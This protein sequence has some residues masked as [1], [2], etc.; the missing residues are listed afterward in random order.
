MKC[1]IY[2][3]KQ[4]LKTCHGDILVTNDDNTVT[5]YVQNRIIDMKEKEKGKEKKK[6]RRS[7]II[8]RVG[9]S[10]VIRS[11]KEVCTKVN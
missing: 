3:R 5:D 9:G 6:K 11:F 1:L 2:D 8:E 4:Q 10:K 7:P